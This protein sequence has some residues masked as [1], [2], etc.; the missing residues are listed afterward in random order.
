M[1]ARMREIKSVINRRMCKMWVKAYLNR[2]ALAIYIDKGARKK[3][4]DAKA[5]DRNNSL[6][7]FLKNSPVCDNIKMDPYPF[8]WV[9][10]NNFRRFLLLCYKLKKGWLFSRPRM[11]SSSIFALFF[12]VK[13]LSLPIISCFF[14]SRRRLIDLIALMRSE[15]E[16]GEK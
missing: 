11:R 6:W 16:S 7:F 4:I 12:Q 5:N 8:W 9:F 14:S 13:R 3:W 10:Y 2:S 15:V 1:P